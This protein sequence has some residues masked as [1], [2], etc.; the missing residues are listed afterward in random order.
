MIFEIIAL[1]ILLGSLIGMGVIIWRKLPV[2][3]ELPEITELKENLFL[4][5]K[6]KILDIPFIKNFSF[7]LFL[8]KILS[9]I[10]VLTM[11]TE[12]KT[13][14]WLQKLRQKSQEKKNFEN[15]NYWQE[16]KNSEAEPGE[17][18]ARREMNTKYSANTKEDKKGKNKPM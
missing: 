4:R 13:A 11:R 12:N 16:L 2:L 18:K 17:S 3:V 5:M 15:D 8:Q 10:R 14:A 9:R 7:E 6:N 1:I